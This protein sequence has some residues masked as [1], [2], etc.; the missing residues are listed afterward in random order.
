[1]GSV[2]TRA[3]PGPAH[4]GPD[5]SR[6]FFPWDRIAC[7]GISCCLAVPPCG[8]GA[9]WFSRYWPDSNCAVAGFRLEPN[10]ELCTC[11][12]SAHVCCRL[13]W[14]RDRSRSRLSSMERSDG[15][16]QMANMP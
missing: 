7:R 11:R 9:G 5:A 3:A 15:A 12:P 14:L 4:R 1:V 10:P 6:A 2:T 13:R 16:G 8:G